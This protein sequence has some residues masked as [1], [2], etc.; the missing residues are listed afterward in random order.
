MK[1]PTRG[2]KVLLR[3]GTF[4]KAIIEV[5]NSTVKTP[6]SMPKVSWFQFLVPDL[7]KLN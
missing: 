2:S 4:G 7:M 3:I 6:E 1:N 5:F